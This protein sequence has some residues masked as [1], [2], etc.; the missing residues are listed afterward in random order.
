M[1]ETICE[2][3]PTPADAHDQSVVPLEVAPKNQNVKKVVLIAGAKSNHP[4]G[5]HEFFA[6]TA[7]LAKLFCKVPGVVPVMVRDGWPKDESIL[8]GAAAVVFYAD[9]GDTHPLVD[10]GHRAKLQAVLSAGAGFANLHYAVEYPVALQPEVLPWL[11]GVYETGYSANPLW[12]ANVG[13]LPAHP[14]AN[15]VAPFSIDDEWYFGMRWIEPEVGITPIVQAT[16]TDDKRITAE[17]AS[18]PGRIETL[19]WA[20]ERSGGGRGFGFTGGHWYGNWFDSPDTPDASK[21]R[22]VVVNGILWAAG[23]AVPAEGAN[24]E[25]DPSDAGRWLDTK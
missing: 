11:G 5:Q 16:P 8:D 19:A 17:T 9:G 12:R 13:S 1:P 25:T 23:V 21:Q 15:G 14:I 4:Q 3:W 20:Y 10:A 24:V 18:H 6:V 2:P 22:R 7:T